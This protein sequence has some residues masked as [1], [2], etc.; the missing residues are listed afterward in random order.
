MYLKCFYLFFV[1]EIDTASQ[2][3]EERN[4]ERTEDQ[5]EE[6]AISLLEDVAS[7][8]DKHTAIWNV[9]S[10]DDFPQLR[11]AL[12]GVLK[13]YD[14]VTADDIRHILTDLREDTGGEFAPP[15]FR[16]VHVLS[17]L[18]KEWQLTAELIKATLAENT[19]RKQPQVHDGH[20]RKRSRQ[21]QSPSSEQS[22]SRSV[23]PVGAE[24]NRNRNTSDEASDSSNEDGTGSDWEDEMSTEDK[25]IAALFDRYARIKSEADAIKEDTKIA[26]ALDTDI[27]EICNKKPF[28]SGLQERSLARELKRIP[29]VPNFT[30]DKPP[31]WPKAIS[32]Y[33]ESATVV[34][35]KRMDEN[36]KAYERFR[37]RTIRRQTTIRMRED[38]RRQTN[39][40]IY[41]HQMR[42]TAIIHQK[43]RNMVKIFKNILEKS[44]DK[45]DATQ[46][47]ALNKA[48]KGK[49]ELDSLAFRS[50]RI[51]KAMLHRATKDRRTTFVRN[52]GHMDKIRTQLV[53]QESALQ[54]DGSWYI[55]NPSTLNA[56]IELAANLT[57]NI[58]AL[59]PF[60]SGRGGAGYTH[61]YNSYSRGGSSSG[62]RGGYRGRGGWR[63]N[64]NNSAQR[65]GYGNHREEN[66]GNGEQ[67]KD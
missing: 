11:N 65:Y 43:T 67:R 45:L 38:R 61:G 39:Q 18:M 54:D 20:Q 7:T 31:R 59:T 9:T 4:D 37:Q 40:M 58:S 47:A 16:A 32:A 29:W 13:K 63:G 49:D 44:S 51:T 14:I 60:P 53:N 46:S 41:V 56:D 28:D 26:K 22:R 55:V 66:R 62:W 2:Q 21:A 52:A 6:D 19:V 8:I 25:S 42:L 23:S 36:A 35:N 30:V 15:A 10:L 17:L 12:F 50:I 57:K 27:A 34:P 64:Y 24:R 5:D 33:A 1:D 3:S 48:L